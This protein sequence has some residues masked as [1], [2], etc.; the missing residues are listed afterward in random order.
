MSEGRETSDAGPAA[1]PSG[2]G[3]I[4]PDITTANVGAAARPTTREVC[5]LPL[6]FTGSGGEY[7]RIWIVNVLLTIA[8]L[9]IYSAWAKVRT[10]NYF[11]RHTKLDGSSFEYLA[12]PVSILKGRLIVGGF[13]GAMLIAEHFSFA[14]YLIL[15]AT[16]LLAL[17]AI[18]VL[19]Q[20]F[21]ARHSAYR[22]VRFA[23]HGRIGESYTI[24]L[25]TGLLNTF[26][27]GLAF[28][29]TRWSLVKFFKSSH[30]Y[31][32]ERF[33]FHARIGQFYR[34]YA[35]AFVIGFVVLLAFVPFMT[36]SSI[37][38]PGPNTPKLP[39]APAAVVASIVLIYA[40]ILLAAAYVQAKLFNVIYSSMRLGPHRLEANLSARWMMWLHVSNLVAVLFSLGFLAPWAKVRLARYR[41]GQTKVLASGPLLASNDP[42]ARSHGAAG[43]A[44]V[45]LG[46]FDFD[47][48]L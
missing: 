5:P 19:S 1:L 6:T 12:N 27:L 37:G 46:D 32:K 26:S 48:G 33:T 24:F 30:A 18:A 13:V 40:G 47:M 14:L 35:V 16:V 41:I 11:Y 15:L 23:F 31:G 36:L 2:L 10:K 3:D 44:A 34:V 7:F 42:N 9:G 4:D 25:L 38:E 21:N 22:N 17:P 39:I 43:D 8:T 45:D 29:Y 28:P 20:S